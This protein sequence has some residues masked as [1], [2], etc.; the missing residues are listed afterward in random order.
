MSVGTG[1]SKVV[2]QLGL[3]D[4]VDVKRRE[5]MFEDLWK[6]ETQER[7]KDP[8]YLSNIESYFHVTTSRAIVLW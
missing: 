6:W 4:G 2:R 1:A 8:E 5:T 3:V 7:N